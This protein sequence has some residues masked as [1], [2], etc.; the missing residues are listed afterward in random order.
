MN[1][2]FLLVEPYNEQDRD[3]LASRFL[4]KMK[5]NRSFLETFVLIMKHVKNFVI[6]D[7]EIQDL[8]LYKGELIYKIYTKDIL[9]ANRESIIVKKLNRFEHTYEIRINEEYYKHRILFYFISSDES[10]NNKEEFFV[11]SYGFSKS[12]NDF[13]FTDEFAESNDNIKKDIIIYPTNID[14]WLGGN[15]SELN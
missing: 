14:Y 6:K 12:Q 10:L 5:M 3:Y 4:D 8:F 1:K 15:R 13:D 7:D 11:L 9:G 2:F